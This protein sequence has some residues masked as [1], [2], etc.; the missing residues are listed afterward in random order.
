M[1]PKTNV[2]KSPLPRIFVFGDTSK[3]NSDRWN[4]KSVQGI[5]S[6]IKEERVGLSDLKGLYV[7]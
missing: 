1:S 2:T 3:K 5:I 7:S 6:P 4:K